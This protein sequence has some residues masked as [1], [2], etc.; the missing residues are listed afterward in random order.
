MIVNR[1]TLRERASLLVLETTKGHADAR[2]QRIQ[3]AK[4]RYIPRIH[5][6]DRYAL[7]YAQ[8]VQDV[9]CN[10]SPVTLNKLGFAWPGRMCQ[11]R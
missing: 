4:H 5:E 3:T 7:R 1:L 2:G 8:P 10:E 6:T 9:S 11:R